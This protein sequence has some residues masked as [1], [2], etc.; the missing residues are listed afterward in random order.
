MI[1]LVGFMGA[2]KTTIGARLA[3]R[4][5]KPFIDTDA[6]IERAAGASIA[7]IFATRGER[8]F[9]EIERSSIEAVL[10]RRD[11]I[12]SL[13][14]GALGD[15][16]TRAALEWAE[17]VF[18]DVS[19]SEAMRRVGSTV[20][21]PMLQNADPKALFDERRAVFVSTAGITVATDGRVVEEIVEELASLFG[22][23]PTE[24]RVRVETEPPYD[25][26]VGEGLLE[27]FGDL[28]AVP[29]TAGRAVLVTHP[30]LR[31]YAETVA[32]SLTNID[33]TILEVPEGETTKQL[34]RA[35]ALYDGFTESGL[36]RGDIVVSVGGGVVCDLAGF[37]ASTYHRGLAIAHAPT[38]LLAQMDAAIGGKTALNLDAGKNLI[39][40]FHQ[41][42]AVICDVG[43]LG[44]LPDAEFRSGLAE[45]VKAGLIGDPGLLELL[46]TRT[47]EINRRDPNVLRAVILRCVA[48]KASVVAADE[49]ESGLRAIL[50]YGH[51]FGHA[52]ELTSRG[53]R[54]GEAIS[55]GMM[56]AAYAARELDL[57]DEGVVELHRN[58]LVRFGLPVAASV[59][60]EEL[61]P[62]MMQ[63]KK[64]DD[65]PRFVLL[66]G[67][68]VPVHGVEVPRDLL[69]NA[70]KRMDA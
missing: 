47:E 11:A 44:T 35:G 30:R 55:L 20:D 57:I 50:N 63:D 56:A 10:K 33:A 31:A 54:H 12:V 29:D 28:I 16:A 6:E 65:T 66:K 26:V 52:L 8:G 48:L 2:G 67:V 64:A 53:L 41:P 3:D 19:F 24:A 58:V 60:L 61:E 49:R 32:R 36:R 15:P 38:S 46:E 40:T 34:S 27:R 1:V 25:V 43:T 69:E 7:E 51:T 42:I 59:T 22:G 14:G 5:G 23:S 62:F 21:R 9:R 17:V 68:G 18:L 39:G 4:L 45:V 37:V 13:G 70:L